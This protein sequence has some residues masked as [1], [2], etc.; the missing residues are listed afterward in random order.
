MKNNEPIEYVKDTFPEYLNNK[1]RISASDIKNFLKSPDYYYYKKYVEVRDAEIARHFLIGSALH[2]LILEPE[3]FQ[4]NYITSPKFDKRTTQGKIDFANFE[5]TAKGKVILDVDE[6]EMIVKMG[7]SAAANSTFIDLIVDS[8]RE[9]SC[10]TIDA[11]TGLRIKLRP[12]SFAK[13]KSTI[14]DIKSCQ[15][16]SYRGFRGDV[17]KFGY[18]ISAAFYSDFLNRDNYIFCAIEKEKPYQTALYALDDDMMEY[19]RGQY[20]MALD[21]IKWC[22]ENNYY[23]SYNEF[24]LLKECYEL[25][26]LDTFFETAKLSEKITIIRK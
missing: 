5:R 24:E 12:D 14:T 7:E 6:Y 2:E 15:S 23:P 16:S 8:Y 3:Y 4:S 18:S 17:Y 26:S 25:Q 19:G 11:E 10:Y 20:R 9:L 21:L 22:N 1:E 13:N